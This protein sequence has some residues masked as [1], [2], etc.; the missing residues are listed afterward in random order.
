MV[1]VHCTRLGLTIFAFSIAF[2]QAP[3]IRLDEGLRALPLEERPSLNHDHAEWPVQE[4]TTLNAQG[5]GS[6]RAALYL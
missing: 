3:H 5:G 1:G 4:A 6:A 2:F